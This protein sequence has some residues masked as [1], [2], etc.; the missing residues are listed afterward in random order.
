[1]LTTQAKKPLKPAMVRIVRMKEEIKCVQHG[2]HN[3]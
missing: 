1:M 2:S 3:P